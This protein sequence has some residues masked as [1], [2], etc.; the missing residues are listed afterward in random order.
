MY[1]PRM[2]DILID[3]TL[4]VPDIPVRIIQDTPDILMEMLTSDVPDIKTN[5]Q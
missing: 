1:D 2:P 5:I 4:E 3:V